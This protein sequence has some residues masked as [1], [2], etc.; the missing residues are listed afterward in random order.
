MPLLST[1]LQPRTPLSFS[2]WRWQ[3]RET[4]SRRSRKIKERPQEPERNIDGSV[5]VYTTTEKSIFQKTEGG[6][7]V[8]VDSEIIETV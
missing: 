6:Q 8:L 1:C 7:W 2:R 4:N 3:P 5:R